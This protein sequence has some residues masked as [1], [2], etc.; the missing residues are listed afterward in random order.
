MASQNVFKRYEMK[1]LL[2]KGQK[3]KVLEAMKPFM[4]QDSFGHSIIRNIYFDTDSY[5]LIR[6]S[7][8]KPL[9]KEK[10][11][12]RSYRQVG[13]EDKVFIEIK[14]KYDDVVYKRRITVP[15][16]TAMEYLTGHGRLPEHSQIGEEIDY[17]L[18]FYSRPAPKIFISYERDAY[19][20][21]N[22]KDFRVT[23]DENILWRETDLS[24][25]KGIYGTP[26]LEPGQTLMEI[27]T[28][29]SIPLWM[30]QVLSAERIYRTGFSKYGSA[31]MKIYNQRKGVKNYA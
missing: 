18:D 16:Q 21:K 17:F 8:E 3:E 6:N 25:E 5:R 2:T 14:K 12:L 11:R 10:L 22:T 15:E 23:F 24:L 13:P 31:Y 30:A 1:Y 29:Q 28:S 7:L 26:V 9:Y 20:S 27:K 19:F 4:E